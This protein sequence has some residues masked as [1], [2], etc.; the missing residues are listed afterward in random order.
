MTT[1]TKKP[2]IRARYAAGHVVASPTLIPGIEDAYAELA[3]SVAEA[4]RLAEEEDR[5]R[6]RLEATEQGLA[7]AEER[8]ASARFALASSIM[9]AAPRD[10]PSINQWYKYLGAPWQ[11]RSGSRIFALVPGADFRLKGDDKIPGAVCV[12]IIDLDQ[13]EA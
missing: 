5:L 1:M 2:G 9:D 10:V 8:I 4:L 12:A 6:E 3:E 7:E 13:V 11:V